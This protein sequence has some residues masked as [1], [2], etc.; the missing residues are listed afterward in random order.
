[1][2]RYCSCVCVCVCVWCVYYIVCVCNCSVENDQGPL[3]VVSM[4]LVQLTTTMGLVELTNA[5][6]R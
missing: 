6:S 1:M 3:A 2:T 4:R 5:L